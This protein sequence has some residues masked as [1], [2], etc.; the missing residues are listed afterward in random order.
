MSG[1]PPPEDRRDEATD[2]VAE[3]TSERIA[4]L[5]RRIHG[6]SAAAS[7]DPERVES[8][9]LATGSEEAKF[10]KSYVSDPDLRSIIDDGI[11]LHHLSGDASNF[12]RMQRTRTDLVNERGVKGLRQAEVVERGVLGL[13]VRQMMRDG[14]PRAEIESAAR[15]LLDSV[16][17]WTYFVQATDSPPRV[18]R[19]VEVRVVANQPSTFVVLGHGNVKERAKAIVQAVMRRLGQ[20]YEARTHD[21]GRTFVAFIGKFDTDGLVPHLPTRR[22][23][24]IQSKHSQSRSTTPR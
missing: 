1:D 24:G 5:A 12:D 2:R 20:E 10:L 18:A 3:W 14:L 16:R 15:D 8:I 22:A 4:E 17:E 21:E 6:H 19:E 13:F 9:R 7:Q 23:R 11:A